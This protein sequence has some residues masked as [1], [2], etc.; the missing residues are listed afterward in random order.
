MPPPKEE[1]GPRPPKTDPPKA[2]IG[3]TIAELQALGVT[4]KVVTG[5]SD[6]VARAVA[7]QVGLN[8][9][10]V[11]TGDEIRRLTPQAF[12][13]RA[14]ATTIFARVDPDQKLRVIRA[15]QSRGQVAGYL[16]DGIND[17]PPLHV[18]DVGISV[19]N[20]TDVARAAA[21]IV[22]LQPSLAAIAHGV[23]EGRRTFANTLKYIRMGISSNFG[24]M[25]SMAGAAVFLPFLPMLPSQILLN[26]L[27]YDASQTAIPTDTATANSSRDQIIGT[28]R[29]LAW[30]RIAVGT[31]E[32]SDALGPDP[33]GSSE[34]RQ[35]VAVRRGRVEAVWPIAARGHSQ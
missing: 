16:G 8:V 2:D 30:K 5:D 29:M 26:N 31:Q 19:D 25:L 17:A 22:L 1:P 13:A 15:L 6:V 4:L 12:G 23:R 20:G 34:D 28:W 21:D 24:N 18:A 11:L 3:A 32:A 10:G 35:V 7:K 9:T 33:F 14:L 27:I